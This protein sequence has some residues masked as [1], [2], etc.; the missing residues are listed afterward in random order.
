M[1]FLIFFEIQKGFTPRCG[2]WEE[3]GP[4]VFFRHSHGCVMS[5]L[6]GAEARWRGRGAEI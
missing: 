5:M 6:V 4:R 1:I 2:T 3:G